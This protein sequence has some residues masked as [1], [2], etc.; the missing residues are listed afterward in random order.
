M[1]LSSCI[2][3]NLL[4]DI[5]I[6][7]LHH[8]HPV[9]LGYISELTVDSSYMETKLSRC[10]TETTR[11]AGGNLGPAV[12]YDAFQCEHILS[13][14]MCLLDA[15]HAL[16]IK[17]L[18]ILPTSAGES[19]FLRALLVS[20]HCYGPMDPVSNIILKSIWY[21]IAFP[22]ARCPHRITLKHKVAFW[23]PTPCPVWNPVP[24][25]AWLPSCAPPADP[26][27]QSTRSWSTSTFGTVT[28]PDC[29]EK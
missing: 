16:Y 20:G 27:S 23:T 26:L 4:A 5:S 10:L 8:K 6:A 13:L 14:K 15:I 2:G 21:D 1:Q 3:E 29:A 7:S 19:R 28:S 18:A 9:P 24:S 11:G 12:D 25:M 22:R 17:A